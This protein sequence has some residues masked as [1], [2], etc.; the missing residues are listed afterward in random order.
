MNLTEQH[1]PEVNVSGYVV[2]KEELFKIDM[3]S[4][5]EKYIFFA[6]DQ[7]LFQYFSPNEEYIIDN[8]SPFI[9]K[10]LEQVM[11]RCKDMILVCMWQGSYVPCTQKLFKVRRTDNGFCC[12]FNTVDWEDQL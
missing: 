3:I 10:L 5:L 6:E 7:S 9:Q 1:Y 8:Y 2:D 4:I 12:S 11:H